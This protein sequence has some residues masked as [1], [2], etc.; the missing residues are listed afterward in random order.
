[1]NEK[2]N[3]HS[4]DISYEGIL[5]VLI[6]I[7]AVIMLYYLRDIIFILFLAILITLIIVPAVDYLESRDIPRI[8]AAMLI[9]ALIFLFFGS[10]I[11]VIAPPLA[12]Q[13]SQLS[14]IIPQFLAKNSFIIDGTLLKSE[15]YGPLQ[16]VL[17]EASG[18]FRNITSSFFA[19]I[20]NVLG[21]FMSALLTIVISFYLIIEEKGIERFVREVI[22]KKF[23]ERSLKVIKKVQIKLGKWVLGQLTLGF[24]VGIMSYVGLSLLGIT[25]YALV[26]ALIAGMLE[27]VPYIGPILSAIPA[28]VIALTISMNHAFMTLVLYFFIQQFENYL[29][30][31]KVMEK[32]VN[33]HPIVII[34]VIIIGEKIAGITGAILAV[35]VAAIVSIVLDDVNNKSAVK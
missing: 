28:I 2:N 1:M 22:P 5:K 7:S 35:P 6:S 9:F 31:P 34:I 33:L 8:V 29:I 13:L 24:I 21:G 10:L 15:L 11:F 14:L 17:I 27:L 4:L 23:Q 18:Y 16:D 19:G 30:V 12:K 26:L 25:E 3:H 32:S 20:F